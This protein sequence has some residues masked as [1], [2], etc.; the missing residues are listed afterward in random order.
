MI[1]LCLKHGDDVLIGFTGG[2]EEF[3]RKT[4]SEL[5]KRSFYKWDF[6]KNTA[7]KKLADWLPGSMVIAMLKTHHGY[8]SNGM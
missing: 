4:L 1:D 7:G 3:T 5:Q 6:A 2:K 8:L